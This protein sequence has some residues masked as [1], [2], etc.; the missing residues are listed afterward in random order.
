MPQNRRVSPSAAERARNAIP[1]QIGRDGAWRFSSRE[2]PEDAADDRGL[3]FIDCAFA[4][5]RLALAIGTFH[6]VIPIAEPAAGL[7]L[8]YPSA[9]TSVGLGGKVFQEQSVHRAFETDM[10]F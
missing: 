4:P 2:F 9:Q 7:A 3:G 1:V 8:L 10:K 6:H 5:N